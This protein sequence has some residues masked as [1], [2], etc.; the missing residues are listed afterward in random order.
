MA[1]LLQEQKETI[2]NL[3]R[4]ICKAAWLAKRYFSSLLKSN[5]CSTHSYF[6]FLLGNKICVLDFQPPSSKR[7]EGGEEEEQEEIPSP[8]HAGISSS[9]FMETYPYFSHGSMM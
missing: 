1:T 2:L 4:T 7:E 9:S 3:F 8:H 6:I 5:F